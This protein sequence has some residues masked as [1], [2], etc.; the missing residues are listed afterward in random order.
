MDKNHGKQVSPLT[1]T[2]AASIHC[3]GQTARGGEVMQVRTVILGLSRSPPCSDCG[4]DTTMPSLLSETR[5]AAGGQTFQADKEMNQKSG[6]TDS[7][8]IS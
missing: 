5:K 2:G 4:V 1:W 8:V 6:Q 7:T 3:L